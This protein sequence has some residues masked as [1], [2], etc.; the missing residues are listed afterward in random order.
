MAYETFINIVPTVLIF[1]SLLIF[2][3]Y[4]NPLMMM[5]SLSIIPLGVIVS[6]TIGTKAQKISQAA[7][8]YWDKL[9]GRFSDG[10]TNINILRLFAREKHEGT[11]VYN[12]IENATN[13]QFKVRKLW[14]FLNAG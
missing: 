6:V 5:I 11:I 7:N 2:G 9:Y 13:E 10:L 14:A 1:V 12:M 3:L 4:I 8:Q